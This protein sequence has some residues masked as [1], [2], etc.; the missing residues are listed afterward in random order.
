MTPAT[1]PTDTPDRGRGGPP[2]VLALIVI[3]GLLAGVGLIAVQTLGLAPAPPAAPTTAP[4][5]NAAQ[6]TVDQLVGV[7]GGAQLQAAIA[8]RPY[9]PPET[10]TLA[11]VPRAVLQ[12]VLPQDPA[13]GYIVVYEL[14]TAAQ[15]GDAGREF[16]AYLGSG[17][18]RV[19]FPIDTRFTVRRVESTVV[20]FHWSPSNWPDPR[21][22]EIQAVLDGVGEGIPVPS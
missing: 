1:S 13:H 17:V 14:P 22:P 5:G 7:L 4:A 19:N 8:Q 18:G 6:A 20:F 12:V 3:V 21:S 9:R 2:P 11:T 10:T 16:A 15:A